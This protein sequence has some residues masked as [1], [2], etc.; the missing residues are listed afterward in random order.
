MGCSRFL[1]VFVK[2]SVVTSEK[3]MKRV[4]PLGI[5]RQREWEEN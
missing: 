4:P 1:Q 2:P 3:E 5:I